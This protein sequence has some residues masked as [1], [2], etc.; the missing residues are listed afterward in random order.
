LLLFITAAH[1]WRFSDAYASLASSRDARAIALK[2]G[3][4]GQ[5]VVACN[6]AHPPLTGGQQILDA[7]SSTN[8]DDMAAHLPDRIWLTLHESVFSPRRRFQLMKRPD[9][10]TACGFHFRQTVL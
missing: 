8:T 7:V 1:R 9:V 6:H 3:L 4:S 5:L 2:I 10:F